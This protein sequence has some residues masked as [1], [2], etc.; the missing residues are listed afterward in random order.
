MKISATGLL[1]FAL[2]LPA[3][4]Q[5]TQDKGAERGGKRGLSQLDKDNDG[6]ISRDEWKGKTDRFDRL[7]RFD[8]FGISAR[9]AP[10]TFECR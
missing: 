6:R 1:I 2:A 9:E 3:L 7:D 5:S 10:G 4:A 8:A